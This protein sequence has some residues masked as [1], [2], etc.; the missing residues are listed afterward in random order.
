MMMKEFTWQMAVPSGPPYIREYTDDEKAAF[1]A[2]RAARVEVAEAAVAF[3]GIF[4]P[5]SDRWARAEKHARACL[6]E[7][8]SDD[9]GL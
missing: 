7:L 1:A 3:A 2:A 6:A 9:G 5:T 4:S 8:L